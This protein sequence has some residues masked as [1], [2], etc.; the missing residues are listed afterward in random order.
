MAE[1]DVAAS[2]GRIDVPVTVRAAARADRAST[3]GV[4]FDAEKGQAIGTHDLIDIG[5]SL[6]THG[7]SPFSRGTPGR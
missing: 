4:T 5:G 7:R 1:H 6:L 3:Q 2:L